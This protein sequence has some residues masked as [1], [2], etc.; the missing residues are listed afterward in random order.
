ML[1]EEN[2]LAELMQHYVLASLSRSGLFSTAIFSRRHLPA[3]LSQT[4]GASR[5]RDDVARMESSIGDMPL[6]IL[7]L[8]TPL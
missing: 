4:R 2:M 3:Y 6:K 8:T 1:G 5:T 7:D